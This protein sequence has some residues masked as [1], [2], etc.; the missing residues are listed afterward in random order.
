MMCICSCNNNNKR[1]MIGIGWFVNKPRV[2]MSIFHLNCELLCGKNDSDVWGEIWL[3]HS[4][5][6]ATWANKSASV[7]VGKSGIEGNF[8]Q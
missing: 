5:N 6:I 7:G 2:R 1:S 4:S 8:G 3:S